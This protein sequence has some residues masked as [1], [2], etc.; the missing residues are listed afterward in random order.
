MVENSILYPGEEPE[1]EKTPLKV[2]PNPFKSSI[3]ISL[4]D[5]SVASTSL[6]LFDNTGKVVYAAQYQNI[7]PG[8][9]PIDLPGLA[10][11]IYHYRIINDSTVHN[12]TLIKIGYR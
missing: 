12:G 4:T 8:F 10:A 9:L 1:P 3:T 2:Y 7:F 6:T 5:K 11:G